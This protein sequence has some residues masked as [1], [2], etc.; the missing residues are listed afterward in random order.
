MIN[1]RE[2][3]FGASDEEEEDD[4]MR[5][6]QIEYLQEQIDNYKKNP[7][8]YIDNEATIK[9]LEREIENVKSRIEDPTILD[10]WFS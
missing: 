6:T 3:L 4:I 10:R 8:P 5:C 7:N 1:S 2:W 9:G